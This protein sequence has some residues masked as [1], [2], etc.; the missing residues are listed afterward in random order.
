VRFADGT[1]VRPRAVIWA[2]GFG[3]DHSFVP[4]LANAQP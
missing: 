1:R 3:L 2:T 4:T